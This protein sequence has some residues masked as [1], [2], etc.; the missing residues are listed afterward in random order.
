MRV[1][2]P[3]SSSFQLVFCENVNDSL[4]VIERIRNRFDSTDESSSAYRDFAIKL[5]VGVQASAE[6]RYIFV[7]VSEWHTHETLSDGSLCRNKNVHLLIC[8][9]QLHHRGIQLDDESGT[10]HDNYVK[11]RNLVSS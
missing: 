9:V 7:P 1:Q 8:E 4:F 6:G 5:T 10:V 11:M 2:F 3:S